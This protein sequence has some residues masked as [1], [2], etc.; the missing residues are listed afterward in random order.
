[1]RKILTKEIPF[2]LI[3]VAV[4]EVQEGKP[5]A[6]ELPPL[7]WL[8]DYSKERSQKILDKEHKGKQVMIFSLEV[9][10]R[11][12]EMEVEEFIK[13]AKLKPSEENKND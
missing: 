9:V 11:T 2:T 10:K 1:M 13:I 12:Y 8:G 3:K 5:V 4:L 6:V 7:E